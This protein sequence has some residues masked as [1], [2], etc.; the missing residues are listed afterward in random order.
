MN[1][2]IKQLKRRANILYR[3]RKKGV[4]VAT[5]QR[6]IFYE[7]GGKPETIPQVWKLTSEYNFHVQFEIKQ[8]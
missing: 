1:L 8:I 4:R 7:Y 2:S 6:I 5:R 3:L